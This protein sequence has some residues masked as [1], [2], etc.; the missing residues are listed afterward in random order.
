MKAL[1]KLLMF[2]S[3]LCVAKSA[4]AHKAHS[5]HSHCSVDGKGVKVESKIDAERKKACGKIANAKWDE[6]NPLRIDDV[7]DGATTPTQPHK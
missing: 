5:H 1:L 6:K 3:L 4:L 2:F 7:L